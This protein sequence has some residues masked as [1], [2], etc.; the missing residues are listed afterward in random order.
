[1]TRHLIFGLVFATAAGLMIPA[2]G[3][4]TPEPPREV[5]LAERAASSLAQ[6]DITV[7]GPAGEIVELKPEDLRIKVHLRR[8]DDFQLDRLCSGPGA[9]G[10]DGEPAPVTPPLESRASYLFYFDQ[11]YLTMPGRMRALEL[12]RELV[13][14]LIVDGS[15]AMIVSNAGSLAVVEPFTDDP[16]RLIAALDRLQGD[17]TQWDTYANE[18]E[19]RIRQVIETLNEANR[20]E[21][22]IGMARRY[23]REERWR[24]DKALRRLANTL[25]RLYDIEY[26]KAAFYFADTMRSNAG[27]HYTRFFG[28]GLRGRQ[29]GLFSMLGDGSVASLPFDAVV[30]Q[31]SVQGIRFYAVRAL[32]L[33]GLSP[34]LQPSSRGLT[35]SQG[36]SGTSFV[37][38]QHAGDTLSNMAS[39]TGGAA[40]VSGEKSSRIA[41]EVRADLSCLYVASFD[42]TGLPL[43][44]ALRVI[45]ELRDRPDIEIR[46][47]GRIV[48]QSEAARTT[49]RLL[50][51]F[52]MPEENGKTQGLRT[53]LIP[54]GFD[55][56]RFRALLQVSVPGSPIPN[57]SW[58]MGASVV[59]KDK[60]R[61]ESSGSLSVN[62]TGV[63][64]VYEVELEFQPGSHEII[65]VARE[66]TTDLVLS[67]HIAVEWPEPNRTPSLIGPVALLQP[68]AGAFL[69]GGNGRSSGSLAHREIDPVVTD[70]P[71]AL[72]ALVC[73]GWGKLSGISV[74]RRLVCDA[75]VEFDRLLLEPG[76]TG[77]Q[78]RPVQGRQTPGRGTNRVR[79]HSPRA[80][81]SRLR[82]DSE[83]PLRLGLP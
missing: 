56:D 18:E 52:T 74:D 41:D 70:R 9:G 38:H 4:E 8:I 77:A 20:V 33:P 78:D 34:D 13:R 75:P 79:G 36:T 58:E 82:S 31:A 25:T 80:I 26:P 48:I 5:G 83:R 23:Q 42:P 45:V 64:V 28:P 6:I 65:V 46:S 7:I 47:R 62:R 16:D 57:A 10:P 59:F 44:G 30:N 17:R 50:S 63:P 60:V 54:I 61:D 24:T 27:E 53:G 68:T 3:Q 32:G 22:A 29:A 67:E 51:A 69:R 37:R 76:E 66:T 55:G 43:D 72:I 35:R 1:L 49:S 11:P 71:V 40:F 81:G 14:E 15:R 73:Q 39:E 12:S 19:S 21:Q 2:A